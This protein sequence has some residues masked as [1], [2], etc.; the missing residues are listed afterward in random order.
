MNNM[1]TIRRVDGIYECTQDGTFAPRFANELDTNTDIT[2][3]NGSYGW[4]L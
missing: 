3:L 1:V 4:Y 2:V